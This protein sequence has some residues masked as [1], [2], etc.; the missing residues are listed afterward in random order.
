MKPHEQSQNIDEVTQ[1]LEFEDE[2]FSN[3]NDLSNINSKVKITNIAIEGLNNEQQ[4]YSTMQTI[5]KLSDEILSGSV[6]LNQDL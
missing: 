3:I 6:D 5:K 1:E 2:E 4:F